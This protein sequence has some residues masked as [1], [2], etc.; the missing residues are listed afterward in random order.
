M[1]LILAIVNNDD[2]P[3]VTA[4]L[5]KKGIYTT[6]IASTGGFLSAGN[7]TFISG[8]EDEKVDEVIETIKAYSKKRTQPVPAMS[9]GQLAGSY[10]NQ[11]EVLVGGATI[12]VLDVE[13]FTRA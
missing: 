10:V 8:V 5:N 11:A 2:G 13:K 7:M 1:K 4:Q 3:M 9:M 6:K 12:F